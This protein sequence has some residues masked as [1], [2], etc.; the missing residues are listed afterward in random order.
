[1]IPMP[2]CEKGLF[3]DWP[4]ELCIPVSRRPPPID[5]ELLRTMK[6]VQGIGYAPNPGNRRR[7]QVIVAF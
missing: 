6:V 7:N 4:P 5:P 1:M 3:S 2:Y